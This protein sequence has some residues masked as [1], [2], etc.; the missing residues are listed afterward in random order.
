MITNWFL[1][2]FLGHQLVW[3]NSSSHLQQCQHHISIM[4]SFATTYFSYLPQQIDLTVTSWWSIAYIQNILISVT[5]K[6]G[7][8]EPSIKVSEASK[9]VKVDVTPSNPHK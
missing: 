4:V 3:A 9:L 8:E 7:M 6:K 1:H 2:V 5:Q